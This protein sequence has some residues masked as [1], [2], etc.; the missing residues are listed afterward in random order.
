M[1][2]DFFF[3]D[4]IPDNLF[5]PY[6]ILLY[7]DFTIFNTAVHPYLFFFP[8]QNNSNI[9][10]INQKAAGASVAVYVALR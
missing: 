7:F 6:F 4:C 1:F 3:A 10:K 8:F 5:L 9:R 2:S